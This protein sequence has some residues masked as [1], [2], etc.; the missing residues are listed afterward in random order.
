MDTSF[1]L[2][3]LSGCFTTA[4]GG[5]QV[6]KFVN[7]RKNSEHI[8]KKRILD[9]D[10]LFNDYPHFMS[11]MKNDVT[12]PGCKD[13]KEFFVVDKDAILN[14]SVPRFRYELSPEILPA[15]NKLEELGY[16]EKIQNNCLHYKIDEEFIMQLKSIN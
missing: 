7:D 6:Q 5:W 9:L 2:G 16:I 12:N 4:L 15:L 8:K 14:S 10:R 11:V 1:L 13:I 3:F